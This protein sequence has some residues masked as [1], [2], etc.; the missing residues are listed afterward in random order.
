MRRILSFISGVLVTLVLAATLSATPAQAAPAPAP[1]GSSTSASTT[2][3]TSHHVSTTDHGVK[4]KQKSKKGKKARKKAHRKHRAPLAQRAL[5][6]A[7]TRAGMSYRYG[8]TGPYS[9]DCSGLTQWSYRRAGKSLPRTSSA[10]AA[11]VKRVRSPKLGD[12]VFFH[13]GGRVYHVGLYAG[14]GQVFHASRP[15]TPVGRA[16]I[17][18]RSVFYGRA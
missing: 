5:A 18:T 7:R 3:A 14:K 11:A 6:H 17:W 4:K 12:L 8:A 16:K 9:F 2:V 10:Q 15:G 1:A 13:S